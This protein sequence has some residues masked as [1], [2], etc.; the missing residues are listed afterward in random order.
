MTTDAVVV[1]G[2]ASF[3]GYH[4]ARQFAASGYYVVGTHHTPLAAMD[5]LRRARIDALRPALSQLATLDIADGENIRALTAATR[6]RLWIHQAGI[7]ANFASDQYDLA[8]A[9][10]VNLLPLAQI[11][12]AVAEIG[13][14]VIMTGSGM[15]YG[16]V[17]SPQAEDAGCWP[18]LPYGLARL[19]VTLRTRQLSHRYRVPTRIARVYTV[20]GELDRE[21]CLV[22]RLYHRLARGEPVGLAPGVARD[23]CDVSD[24]V[25]GYVRLAADIAHGP[26]FDIINLS[27]GS[28]TSLVEVAQLVAQ[29]LG[30]DPGLI[31][32]DPSMLRADEPP[33]VCGDSR[34]AF[35]RLN[36]TPRPIA[37]GIKRIAK[38]RNRAPLAR[39]TAAG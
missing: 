10:A 22:T 19:A 18:E 7:G 31:L 12:A 3:L 35:A 24:I 38:R 32:H 39:V 17:A 26:I 27:R 33:V 20:F 4:I 15:E 25:M 29:E 28:A 5:V 16:A 30:A 37:E 23:I 14:A 13:G 6:P 9:N 21:N 8:A 11:Y 2:V 36:W 1:T 34:K